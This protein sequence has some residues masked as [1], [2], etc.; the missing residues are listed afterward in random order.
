MTRLIYL[1]YA[2]TTPI[3][4][5]ISEAII[6]CLSIDGDFGNPASLSHHYGLDAGKLVKAARKHVA[7]LIHAQPKEIIW[8]SGA[9]ESNNLALKGIVDRYKN[10]NKHIITSKIEHKAILDTCAE[11]ESQGFQVTYLQPEPQ[12]GII[13]PQQVK[14]AIQPNTILISLMMVNNE[15]GTLTDIQSI[16]NL[17][18]QH[19]ILFHVDAAQAVGKTAI[20]VQALHVDLMSLSAHKIYGPKGIGALYVRHDIQKNL[21]TQIHGGGHEQGLRSGTLATHQIVGMGEA[22]RLA[23]LKWAEEQQ[24]ISKLRKKL[25]NDLQTLTPIKLNGHPEQHVANYLNVS[26]SSER[27]V[28]IIHSIKKIA[29][30]SSGSACNSHQAA[31][32][33][34]L[35]ALGVSEHLAGHT[36]RFSFGA[37]TTEQDIEQILTTLSALLQ[38]HVKAIQ[39]ATVSV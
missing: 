8:T 5:E 39:H 6:R 15:I 1:D 13:H 33:H 23:N 17:A 11:L 7:N 24:R 35:N 27:A 19:H 26:F 34:V 3:L 4:P 29:A 20:D 37:Y 12:T 25:L 14:N 28:S 38:P 21:K 9:T 22:C 32:S 2:A 36:V 10:Q 18:H 30:V 16:G 31:P